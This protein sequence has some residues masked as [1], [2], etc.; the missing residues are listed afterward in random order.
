MHYFIDG[1]NLMFRVLRAGND[2]QKQREFIVSD[3]NEKAQ[4]LNLDV[5]VVFDAQY[6]SGE[7]SRSHY[8][9]LE[10]C[11]TN[12]NETAD[13]YILKNIKAS[14]SPQNETVVTSDNKL[15]WGV[16]RLLAKTESIKQFMSWLNKRYENRLE[17][18]RQEPKELTQKKLSRP[19]STSKENSE[20]ELVPPQP[21]NTA[22]NT[23]DYYLYQF[24]KKFRET[25]S[26]GQKNQPKSEK[27]NKNSKKPKP[28]QSQESDIER[29]QRIFEEKNSR[30]HEDKD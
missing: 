5:T 16:R 11:F 20:K 7:E 15:A 23:F 14:P 13:E 19:N 30:K 21:G 28:E 26:K 1:Y 10:I 27:K 6:Q 2:L 18:N 17:K 9:S 29:W 22:A 25:A 4:V 24:E 3:L 12:Q 8:Q